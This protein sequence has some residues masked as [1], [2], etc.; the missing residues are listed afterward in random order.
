MTAMDLSTEF[1][2]AS[3]RFLSDE[4]LPK[5]DR[6]LQLLSDE[7]VWWRP[8]EHTNSIGNLVL[9]LEGNVRQYVVSGVGKA[10]DLRR[11]SEEFASDGDFSADELRER[12]RE[13]LTEVSAVLD[14]LNPD[15][16]PEEREIQG[17]TMPVFQAI[18]HA[19][20]HFS[21]HT[22]QIIHITK[23]LTDRDLEFYTFNDGSVQRRW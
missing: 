7:S 23:Q 5:I 9:H 6:C 21:M 14:E 4:Y 20:E 22:G 1:I 11:R 15:A 18:Y 8:N 10:P 13:T 17:R 16:L 3:R 12:L 19:V 2:R